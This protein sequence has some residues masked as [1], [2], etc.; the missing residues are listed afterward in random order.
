M[1]FSKFGLAK[2]L[3][4][5]IE[6][7]GYT[8]PTPIQAEAI[9][10]ILNGRDIIATA[11]TGTGKT[12]GFTLPMLQ[13]L[14]SLEPAGSK[15]AHAL[16]LAPTRELAAQI[17]ESV[18]AYG[19]FT[20]LRC[21]TVFGGVNIRPQIQRLHKGVDVLIATP[22][23]LLDLQNQKAVNLDKV[24]FFVL[25]EADRMLDMG[26]IP[27]IRRI[28]SSLPAKKQSLLF[29]ATFSAELR[30]LGQTFLTKPLQIDVSPANTTVESVEQ[31]IYQVDKPNKGKLLVELLNQSEHQQI[32]VFSRTKHGADK[33][34]RTL[35][36]QNIK[37]GAI[38]GNKTQAARKRALQDFSH[39]KL[40]VLVATDIASRGIDIK[41]LPMVVNFDLP[42]VAEDYV[43]RIGRT[44]RAGETGQAISLVCSEEKKQLIAI[45]KL[46]GQK[47]SVQT[48]PGI[49]I[50]FPVERTR[51]SQNKK[52]Y[53][54]RP[55]GGK[56]KTQ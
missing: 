56:R 20:G 27:D 6:Q 16:I 54:Q 39:G 44:G 51:P 4:R 31:S 10:A 5:A 11:R 55:P 46:T 23:R 9:P 19:R 25:D 47:L 35:K 13:I 15:S 17:G 33:L 53:S 49:T 40:R 41:Q 21:L 1:S 28:V 29:S 42:Y 22:G 2:T 52:R 36:M 3:L 12:A 7:S 50:E 38:H 30:K 14:S 24:S 37:A 48:Q 34:T 8:Q 32:L 26:F 45:E 43:H 18:N